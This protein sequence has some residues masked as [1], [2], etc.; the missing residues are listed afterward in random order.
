MELEGR[1]RPVFGE[2]EVE[3]ATVALVVGRVQRVPHP[4]ALQLGVELAT[5]RADVQ[6]RDAVWQTSKRLLVHQSVERY[7]LP[8][9]HKHLRNIH[10]N[11]C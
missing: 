4:D 3:N 8:L 5:G 1:N 2:V 9:H 7:W 10:R 11:S 6:T